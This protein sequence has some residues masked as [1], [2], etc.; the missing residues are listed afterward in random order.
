LRVSWVT[1]THKIQKPQGQ[2]MTLGTAKE[3]NFRE[4]KQ[5]INKA[6][7]FKASSSSANTKSKKP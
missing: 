1:F 7:T 3:L 6:V 5:K 2:S 4:G